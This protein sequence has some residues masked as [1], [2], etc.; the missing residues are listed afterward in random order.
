MQ[1][2]YYDERVTKSLKK[3]NVLMDIFTFIKEIE[4]TNK[5][6]ASYLISKDIFTQS[7]HFN[8]AQIIRLLELIDTTKCK[9]S[10]L[11]FIS[12]HNIEVSRTLPLRNPDVFQTT[13]NN[14]KG[15]PS[16]TPTSFKKKIMNLMF[17]ISKKSKKKFIEE[18]LCLYAM[19]TMRFQ[20]ENADY[21]YVYDGFLRPAQA[22]TSSNPPVAQPTSSNPPVAQPTSSN[23]PVAQPTSS[24]TKSPPKMKEYVN[25]D[26]NYI[27]LDSTTDRPAP[28]QI[29]QTLRA[30][31]DL[32]ITRSLSWE[33]CTKPQISKKRYAEDYVSTSFKKGEGF[34][35][36]ITSSNNSN[37][38]KTTRFLD[39]R[40]MSS[41][42]VNI[43]KNLDSR[44]ISSDYVNM[45]PKNLD[46]RKIS[47]D[48]V[49]MNPKNL[50]SR[51]I[52]SDYVNIPK[53][54][55]SRKISS[56]YVNIPKNL[57]SR[58]IS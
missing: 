1:N 55:D 28:L 23:P 51:K 16:S 50:D 46:S 49:N 18:L 45:N 15:C 40:K 21:D 25:L 33:E 6:W 14:L 57:D 53:N 37:Y 58:K 26:N 42:Y 22:S 52:S 24:L 31:A 29:N 43:P 27:E 30:T 47:S 20:I 32:P 5:L 8:N 54:L 10:F 56:D 4:G 38:I 36:D 2:Y 41:D 19:Y 35:A 48:Y 7:M 9:E 3:S 34:I 11:Q 39:S 12:K 17:F 13:N 44:K